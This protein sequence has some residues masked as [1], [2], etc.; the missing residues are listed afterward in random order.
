MRAE[1]SNQ[2]LSESSPIETSKLI[3]KLKRAYDLDKLANANWIRKSAKRIE[4]EVIK[5]L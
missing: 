3:P 2:I 4:P 1:S 5:I